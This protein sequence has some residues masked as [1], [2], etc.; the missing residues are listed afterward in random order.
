MTDKQVDVEDLL[1]FFVHFSGLPHQVAAVQELQSVMP[2]SLLSSGANWKKIYRATAKKSEPQKPVNPIRVRYFSQRDSATAHALRMCFSSSCAMML[3]AM[4]PGTLQGPNGDDIYLGRVLKYGDTTDGMAQ[5][6][7]L[8]SFGV[9]ARMTT[10]ADYRLIEHQIDKGIPVPL[11]F[12]HRGH[13]SKPQGGGHWLCAVGYDSTH[14]IVNDPF[15]EI[16]LVAGNYL[17][18]WGARLRY[19]KK[20]FTPRW[21]VE[22]PGTGW[23]IIASL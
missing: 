14:L 21:M 10:H 23:A 5:V 12:L 9:E 1:P 11:G 6:K 4:K 3:E 7:A 16:D 18:N 17:N 19:S 2:A 20:N 22:G 15:G 8:Q 13:V